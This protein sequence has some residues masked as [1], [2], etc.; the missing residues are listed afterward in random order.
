MAAGTTDSVARA[1]QRSFTTAIR[2]SRS[3]LL[4]TPDA[5]Q[6]GR[7]LFSVQLPRS[8][9]FD[10][11]KGRGYLIQAGRATLVQVPKAS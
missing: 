3:G 7:D 8:A 9:A 11:P 10:R 6:L 4:L 2:Q 1:V 5:P